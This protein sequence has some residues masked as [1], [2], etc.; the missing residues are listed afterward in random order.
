MFFLSQSKVCLPLS[1]Y[2]DA[3]QIVVQPRNTTSFMFHLEPSIFSRMFSKVPKTIWCSVVITRFLCL[4]CKTYDQSRSCDKKGVEFS[5]HW[6]SI[7]LVKR[8]N[9]FPTSTH[10]YVP[11]RVSVQPGSRMQSNFRDKKM[12]CLTKKSFFHFSLPWS[13]EISTLTQNSLTIL[14]RCKY[15]KGEYDS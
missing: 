15:T 14:P 12:V 9:N 7:N 2:P 5:Y 1:N 8:E 13:K 4:Y 10:F 6:L 11:I 3:Y